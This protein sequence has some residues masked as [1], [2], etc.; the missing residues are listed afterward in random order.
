MANVTLCRSHHFRIKA[1]VNSIYS[2]IRDNSAAYTSIRYI[3]TQKRKLRE[4]LIQ[5]NQEINR[6]SDSN[7]SIGFRRARNSVSGNKHLLQKFS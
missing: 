5:I 3:F 6:L 7:S 2:S 4:Q 1:R